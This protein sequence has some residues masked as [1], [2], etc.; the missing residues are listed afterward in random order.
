MAARR[1]PV[2]RIGILTGGGDAPG[3]NA[4]IRAVTRS[5]HRL[6]WEV[7]GIRNGFEGLIT[8]R[9]IN[10][11]D[12]NEVSGILHRGGTILGTSNRANPF[13]YKVTKGGKV[14]LCDKSREV[15]RNFRRLGLSALVVI[16]GDG[17]LRIA[18]EFA[19]MGLPIVGVPK[20]IDNDVAGT[21]T[22]FGFDTA[23]GTATDAL[24]RL[25]STA[26]SHER[27]MVVELMGRYAGWIAL[28]AGIAGGA[29]VILLPEIPFALDAV[30]RKV[31]E[32]YRK[33]RN[34]CIVVAAEGAAPVGGSFVTHGPKEAGREVR[35]G[36]IA[37]WLAERI[38]AET[39]RETRSLVLGHLQRGGSPSSFDRLLGTRLGAA[40]IRA[41]QRGAFGRV[42][43][44]RHP[45]IVE[46]PI[47]R[48][49]AHPNR[50][51]ANCDA[52]RAARALGIGFGDERE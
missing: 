32:R 12:A 1:R 2:R 36:G 42:V 52:V 39:G 47:S 13:E 22:T 16:G 5:A 8:L 34:F 28:H 17:S 18:R 48:A 46:V 19:H 38:H 51:P 25:H 24:D 45:E 29:D 14:D 6:G 30:C 7:I 26:E 40:A 23:V 21:D 27:T 31:R 9:G 4:V 35:L 11:L 33:K 10:R 15:V 44:L 41:I 49:I 37:E 43:C 3:L 50:V 20:T